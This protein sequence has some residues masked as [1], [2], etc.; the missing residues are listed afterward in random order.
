MYWN[1]GTQTKARWNN[2]EC[3]DPEKAM[4]VC[5]ARKLFNNTSIYNEVIQKYENDSWDHYDDEG[6]SN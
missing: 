3:F 2:N 4:L 6:F 1:D 5:M